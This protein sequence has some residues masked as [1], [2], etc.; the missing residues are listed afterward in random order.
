MTFFPRLGCALA[1]ALSLAGCDSGS[2]SPVATAEAPA[3][4]APAVQ[5]PAQE[6]PAQETASAAPLTSAP[7]LQAEVDPEALVGRVLGAEAGS[8]VFLIQPDAA[9]RDLR[10]LADTIVDLSE[11]DATGH[12]SFPARDAAGLE[13]LV[14]APGHALTRGGLGETLELQ[15]EARLE[16][17]AFDASGQPLELAFALVLDG[18]GTPLPVPVAPLVSDGSGALHVT[19][20][21]AGTCEVIVASPDLQQ[22]AR[23]QRSLASGQVYRERLVLEQDDAL[24]RRFLVIV[25]GPEVERAIEDQA[26]QEGAQ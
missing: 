16:L 6:A 1:L 17:T 15:P 22:V 25:G 4:Q 13:V 21:P 14:S 20:L 23:I 10:A 19:R 9:A 12:F 2:R 7:A 18:Q 24:T 26:S 3:T 5:A 11:T 8:E